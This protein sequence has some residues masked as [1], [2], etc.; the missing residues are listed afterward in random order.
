V[1]P[2]L[3]ALWREVA[4]ARDDLSPRL[5]LADAL[6]ERGDPRG[7]L[8]ALQCA[9]ADASVVMG[10]E[11]PD[12][13]RERVAEL[14]ATH[15]NAWLGDAAHVLVRQGSRFAN[16]M[17]ALALVGDGVEIPDE[18]WDRAAR[19]HELAVLDTVRPHKVTAR[20]YGRFL[21]ALPEAPRRVEIH[22]PGVLAGVR[23]T[24]TRWPIR[25]LRYGG[26][27]FGTPPV[28]TELHD[29]ARL[30]PD[31]EVVELLPLHLEGPR[32]RALIDELAYRLVKLRAVK[33]V[34]GWRM[35]GE[36]GDALSHPLVEIAHD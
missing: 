9:G 18:L 24:R 20:G 36:L 35:R 26:Y 25:V 6:I 11:V 1:E 5:V 15:W 34:G 4:A 31:L 10:G 8:I 33:L 16:G 28:P 27:A 30:A 14:V 7:E 23:A 2:D 21:G 12:N 17:L 3:A 13:V 19:H 22:V 29:V 32:L